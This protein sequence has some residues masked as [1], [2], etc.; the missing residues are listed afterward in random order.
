MSWKKLINVLMCV[1]LVLLN[2]RYTQEV[3]DL[4][5]H[6]PQFQESIDQWNL[7]PCFPLPLCFVNLVI[8][9]HPAIQVNAL[10]SFIFLDPAHFLFCPQTHINV[11]FVFHF[12]V[13]ILMVK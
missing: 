8:I 12:I 11:Y 6:D 13:M 1:K 7:S 10:I 5:S 9:E 4:Y 2:S 3:V